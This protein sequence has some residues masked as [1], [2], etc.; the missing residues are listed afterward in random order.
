MRSG[1]RTRSQKLLVCWYIEISMKLKSQQIIV[2]SLLLNHKVKYN[3]DY[4]QSYFNQ[5]MN[6]LWKRQIEKHQ[7]ENTTKHGVKFEY[8]F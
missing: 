7:T 4:L 2:K 6:K 1:H 3:N 5:F 8:S